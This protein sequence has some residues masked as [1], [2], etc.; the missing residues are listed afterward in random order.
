[1]RVVVVEWKDILG[2]KKMS[3]VRV[4]KAEGVVSVKTGKQESQSTFRRL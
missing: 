2:A 4:G 1:M 3:Q